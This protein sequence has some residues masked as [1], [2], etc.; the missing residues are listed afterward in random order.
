MGAPRFTG[1]ARNVGDGAA[2][3]AVMQL[4]TT[5]APRVGHGVL[6]GFATVT[7][8]AGELEAAFA[9]GAGMAGVS[10]R[11]AGEELLDRRAGVRTYVEDGAVMGIP[12]LHPWANRLAGFDYAVDGR[13]LRLPSGPPLVRCEEHGLPIHGLLG[14]SGHWR[15]RSASAAATRARVSAVLDF[16]AHSELLGAFPFPHTLRLDAALDAGGLT[17]ATT[18]TATGAAAVPVAFGFHPYLRLPGVDR[19]TWRLDLPSRRYLF[20]DA[21]G[22]PTGHDED[23]H[24]GRL[25]LGTRAF[26]DGFGRIADGARFAVAGG[27]RRIALTFAKGYPAA[28]VF[29]PPGAQFV[30]FEP[31]TAPTNAL[32]SGDGLRRAAPGRSFTAVFRIA[33]EEESPCLR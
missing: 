33:I 15:V 12:L 17:I 13:T 14:G 27:G 31:M 25:S 10:L 1:R 9:P 24:A 21:R 19:A 11:H 26:D 22:I 30:C 29:S 23:E 5:A 32:R 18:L 7:L 28:Q 3:E 4:V 6:E 2:T 8:A 20:A 16:A